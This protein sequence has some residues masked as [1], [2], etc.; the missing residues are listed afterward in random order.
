MGGVFIVTHLFAIFFNNSDVTALT[1]IATILYSS[2][3]VLFWTAIYANR[4]LPLDFAYTSNFPKHL[5]KS[6]PYKY[7]RHPLYSSYIMAWTAGA[8]AGAPYLIIT[9]AIM[10]YIFVN[11]MIDEEKKFL[12]SDM[13]DEYIEYK[14]NTGMVLPKL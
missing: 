7:V 1:I 12:A 8:L 5:N 6:G 2:S 13:R 10:T 14:K 9:S 11:A 3:L 4:K